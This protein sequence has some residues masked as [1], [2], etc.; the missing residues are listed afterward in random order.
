MHLDARLKQ[1]E[2]DMAYVFD[3]TIMIYFGGDNNLGEEMIWALKDIQAWRRS[4]PDANIKVC[5]LF[6][7]G[8]PPVRIPD[9]IF[10][11]TA[12]SSKGASRDRDSAILDPT[13]ITQISALSKGKII[14]R[15][16]MR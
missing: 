16:W 11:Y 9:D 14:I 5:A 7:A 6:D 8:G 10:V 2:T 4:N 1:M 13:I 15:G 3:W 12:A